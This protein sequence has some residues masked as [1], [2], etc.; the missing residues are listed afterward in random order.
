MALF[1]LTGGLNPIGIMDG[2]DSELA[3]LKG[4]EVM[5]LS[6]AARANSASEVAS[7]DAL[8]GYVF[9]DPALRAQAVLASAATSL[10]LYLADEGTSPKY[11]TLFGQMSGAL[12]TGAST[13]VG[14]H[15]TSGSGK[16]TLW[17]NPGLYAVSLDACASDFFSTAGTALTPGKVLGFGSGADKGKLA[18]NACSNKVANTGCAHFVEFATENTLVTTPNKLV[19]AAEALTRVKIHFTAGMMASRALN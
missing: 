8:D 14:P 3:G 17:A 4:G 16:V 6:T 15:T 13:V 9:A 5:T 2:K 10:P 7:P 19:G 12:G 11:F 1:A 18:H